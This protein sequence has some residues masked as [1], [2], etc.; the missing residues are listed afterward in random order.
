MFTSHGKVRLTNRRY[1]RDFYPVD[2]ACDC[3][4]CQNFSRAYLHHLFRANEVLSAT[5]AA[6]HNIRFYLNLVAG[7]REAIEQGRYSDYKAEFLDNYSF[8]DKGNS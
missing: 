2:P 4:C 7:A 3:Y 6:I 5:L 8:L 1:R